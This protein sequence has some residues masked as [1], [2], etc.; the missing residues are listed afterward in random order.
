MN[1]TK[2]A[3]TIKALERW[4]SAANLEDDET[5]IDRFSYGR[6][7]SG[8]FSSKPHGLLHE[9]ASPS[10]GQNFSPFLLFDNPLKY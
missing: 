1:P 8:A 3:A 6:W 9:F 7:N 2:R 4:A 10:A 5:R